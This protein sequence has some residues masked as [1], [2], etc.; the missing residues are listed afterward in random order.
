[1]VVAIAG[2]VTVIG[3]R[4]IVVV[5]SVPIAVAVAV[6]YLLVQLPELPLDC[7]GAV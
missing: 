5:S 3:V 4:S 2:P 1:M 7:L 6:F